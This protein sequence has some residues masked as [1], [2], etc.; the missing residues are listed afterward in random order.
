ML[1][2]GNGVYQLVP[3]CTEIKET[4][5][6]IQYAT[7]HPINWFVR[8]TSIDN[9]YVNNTIEQEKLF[10]DTIDEDT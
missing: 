9:I 4:S 5:L 10:I 3:S 7:D 8:N 1:F 6:G 2:E